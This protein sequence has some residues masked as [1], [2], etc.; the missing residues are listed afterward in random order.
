MDNVKHLEKELEWF[1]TVLDNRIKNY[2]GDKKKYFDIAQIPPPAFD[3]KKSVYAAFVE[4]NNLKSEER[5][6]LVLSLVPHLRPNILDV[7]FTKNEHFDRGFSEFGGLKGNHHSGFLPTGETGMFI[8]AG[9]NINKRIES[10]Y[11]FQQDHPFLKDSVLMLGSH[12]PGEPA[13]S[14]MLELNQD[15]VEYFTVGE[16]S[17]PAFSTQFPA[18]ILETDLLWDD[19]VLTYET[20]DRVNEIISWIQHGDK[21]RSHWGEN[22]HLRKGYRALFHG[23]PGTGKTLT[24]ALLGKKTEVPVYRIDLSMVVSKFIGETEKN[25]AR[26]FD[27]AANRNWILFFDEADALFGKRTEISDSHDRYANQEVS[28]LLQRVEEFPGV[29][30]LATNLKSNLDDAFIRRFQNVI[31]F[32]VPSR[33]ERLKLWKSA[34]P[35]ETKFDISVQFEQLAEEFELTGA[36]IMNIVQ[37]TLLMLLWRQQET[38]T[39]KLIIEGIRKELQKEGRTL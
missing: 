9:D 20:I 11:L 10:M 27:R 16:I 25:L 19:L 21:L 31:Y 5:L 36:S 7:F 14:A 39:R 1:T 15:Y 28:Y 13:L 30:I 3:G 26:I 24:A 18:K 6:L 29:V 4:K 17:K 12:T 2:F 34:Y 23:P 35:P 33:E 38:I 22:R 32:P 37:F 8:I